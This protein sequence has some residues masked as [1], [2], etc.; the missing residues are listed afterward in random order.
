MDYYDRHKMIGSTPPPP[1][2]Q[3]SLPCS[4]PL[5]AR[6]CWV[7]SS[8]AGEDHAALLLITGEDRVHFV[9]GAVFLSAY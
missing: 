8:S 1:P 6:P 3:S 5:V 4:F 7:V 2:P 9:P